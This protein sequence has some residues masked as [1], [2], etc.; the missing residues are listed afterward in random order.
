MLTEP[1]P[2]DAHVASLAYAQGKPV[3]SACLRQH[4]EDFQKVFSLSLPILALLALSQFLSIWVTSLFTSIMVKPF[5]VNLRFHE[6]FGITTIARTLNLRFTPELRFW[7][8]EEA[9]KV[10]EME[11]L[12]SDLARKRDDDAKHS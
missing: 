3:A 9:D 4:P 7:Y 6:Y 10:Q 12:L 5:G 2:Y 11:N 8:D 1:V